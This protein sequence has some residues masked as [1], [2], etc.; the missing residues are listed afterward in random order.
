MSGRII[1]I[2]ATLAFSLSACAHYQPMPLDVSTIATPGVAQGDLAPDGDRHALLR[3]ALAHDPAVAAARAS[4]SA[5]EQARKAAKNLPP[6]SVSLT[7]EYS[8]DADPARPWLY[9]GAV[10][11]PFDVGARRAGRIT[12]A[13]LG[14]IKARYA[15]AEAVWSVRQRL[16]QGLDDLAFADEDITLS[17]AQLEHRLAY[18]ALMQRRVNAGEE[19]QGLS[20]QAALDVSAAR[21]ALAQAQSRKAQALATVARSLDTTTVAVA[22][23]A[24][25]KRALPDAPDE[26]RL[27]EMVDKSLY[28][29]SDVLL[30]VADYDTAEN[31]LRLAV[32]AQYPDINIAPG[33]TWER[34]IVKLPVSLSLTLPP[35]DGNRAAINSAQ[36]ARPAAA[37]TLEDRVKA[38]RYTALQSA[39]AY[40]TDLAAALT[41]REND[42]PTAQDMATRTERLKNAGATDQGE[43]LLA[44]LNAVQTALNALQ[45]ER[46]ARMDRLTLEDALHQTF[47]ATD[48]QILTDA[49]KTD[50]ARP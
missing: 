20:A 8:K 14:V 37:K 49:V 18:Q 23:L 2:A 3:L 19:A 42:L 34:G 40:R 47:D 30:A 5:A 7:A 29:R 24:F 46:T 17:Q 27:A 25:T 32:A 33:Y 10:G 9:G 15:L 26:T 39:E 21:Q 6:L 38:T 31:D 44:K 50:K 13:D 1:A 16:Y 35:L 11:I 45:A 43:N 4:L 36:S 12:T 41:I 22:S 48:T 28:S